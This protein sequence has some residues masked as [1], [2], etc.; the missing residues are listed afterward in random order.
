MDPKTIAENWLH[1]FGLAAYKGDVAA[2]V[3]TFAQDGFLR[4]LLV[5]TWDLRTLAG[6]DKITAHL[7][8]TLAP[9]HLSHFALD[10]SPALAPEFITDGP[11][12][13]GVG[14]GFVFDM[15][16]RRGQGY[17]RLLRDANGEAWRAVAAC[18]LVAGLKGHEERGPEPG[19]YV[20]ALYF[21]IP[22]RWKSADARTV[23]AGQS[24]LNAAARLEQLSVPTLVVEKAA[25]VGDQWRARYP[26]LS[27]HSIRNFSHLAYQA[28]P[29]TW[30]EFAPRDKMADWLE[31]YTITQD[32]FVWTS[33]HIMPGAQYDSASQRWSVTVNRNG[34]HVT[35]QPAHI[36]C[37]IG[38][39][40]PPHISEVADQDVFRGTVM[41]SGAY[42]GG[43]PFV[44][45]H[46]VVVGA[47]QSSADI[48]QDLAFRG[49]A[50]VT[51]V[52]R[53]STCVVG[54]KTPTDEERAWYPVG[55][56]T[57]AADMKNFSVP[58]KLT[59]REA[60]KANAAKWER[61]RA[62]HAKLKNSGLKLNMGRDGTG[63][64]FLAYERLGESSRDLLT[65][66]WWD[67]GLA[68]YIESGRVE[69]KQ[70][71][72]P[73]RFT[74]DGVTFT[75]D[76]TL[77]ADLVLFATGWCDVR[78]SLKEIFGN[79]FWYCMGDLATVRFGSRQLTS[80]NKPFIV[81]VTNYYISVHTSARSQDCKE[82]YGHDNLTAVGVDHYR[83][84][85]SRHIESVPSVYHDARTDIAERALMHEEL[86]RL[87]KEVADLLH[88]QASAYQSVMTMRAELS[89]DDAVTQEAVG[90]GYATSYVTAEGIWENE[91][92]TKYTVHLPLVEDG[93]APHAKIRMPPDEQQTITELAATTLFKIVWISKA[94]VLQRIMELVRKQKANKEIQWRFNLSMEMED[95]MAR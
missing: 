74:A 15:P 90:D 72:E 7:G 31:Q 54:I 17:V 46:A 57:E 42:A 5:F 87:E 20:A 28:F 53:S 37:A 3:E 24:G 16:R 83:E 51:M 63:P 75:D 47:C 64:L 81:D 91:A 49:A 10:I 66:Y 82:V 2:V 25:R 93:T 34:T 88:Q 12:A 77:K 33:S 4:D 22:P 13:G 80:H 59:R 71:V 94:I 78:E 23:G 79:E 69:V 6:H 58:L 86:N 92:G 73:K 70:G 26:T 40:G 95:Q 14:A 84:R 50:S 21:G 62:V 76:S 39:T 60:L 67:V 11:F 27:L 56:P 18:V 41:H 65:G 55:V 9:A 48:C 32:L 1:T 61:E 44:G 19:V 85:A 30:P 8:P 35:L 68:D 52:Q 45:Q 36:V 38:S 89:L 43:Q 29:S